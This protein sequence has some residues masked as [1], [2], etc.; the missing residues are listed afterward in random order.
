MKQLAIRAKLTTWYSMI[1]AVALCSF[2]AVAYFAMNGSI[3]ATVDADLRARLEGVRAIIDEDAPK[4]AAALEDEIKEFADGLGVD[5]R[6]RVAGAD[7]TVIFSSQNLDPK[8]MRSRYA[9]LSRPFN[10]RL[11]SDAFRVLH[12]QQEIGGARYD[13]TLAVS[14]DGYNR[15]LR[16]FGIG[17]F[18]AVP[19]LLSVAAAGGYWMSR[20]ALE[21]VDEITRTARSIGIRDLA[22]RLA[23]SNSGDELARLAE[24]LNEMLARLETAFQRITQFTADASHELRTPVAVVRTSAELALSKP[25]SEGEYR[26]VLALILSE[27]EKISRLIEQLLELA[28]ADSG[29][30]ELALTRTDLREPLREACRQASFLAESKEIEFR[31]KIPE[32]AIWVAGESSALEKLFMIVL[33]NAVKYTA[34]RGHIEVSIKADGQFAVID[35]NDTGIGIGSE[36]IPHVFERFYRVDKARSRE[37]GGIGLGLAIGK[38]IAQT[39]RGDISVQSEPHKG[40]TFQIKLPILSNG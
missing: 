14:I 23:V 20:R 25:R 17:L 40:S 18:F 9:R 38:W 36:D 30:V 15:A 8:R 1:L 35:V 6:V 11:D 34:S 24:T 39:H 12:V 16:S 2:G 10:Q 27:T 19:A 28:R 22:Q 37:S 33:D 13:I 32:Q 26:E 31:A 29:S 3:R 21:P 5:G 4:G 7:G